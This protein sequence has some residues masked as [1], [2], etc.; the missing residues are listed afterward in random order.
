MGG[1]SL[2]AL[3]QRLRDYNPFEEGSLY[4][5]H[6]FFARNSQRLSVIPVKIVCTD[7]TEVAIVQR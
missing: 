6:A 5:V 4:R 3:D 7:V 1:A 2:S